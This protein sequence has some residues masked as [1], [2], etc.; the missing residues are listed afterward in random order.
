MKVKIEKYVAFLLN[1]ELYIHKLFSVPRV[2]SSKILFKK[3]KIVS[4]A[5]FKLSFPVYYQYI[6][7]RI[8][9]INNKFFFPI[10]D[11]YY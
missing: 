3:K 7:L 4:G 11:P 2:S 1:N 10:S 9:C 5:K 8:P 6:Q